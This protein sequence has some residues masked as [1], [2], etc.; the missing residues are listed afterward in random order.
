MAPNLIVNPTIVQQGYN[1]VTQAISNWVLTTDGRYMCCWLDVTTCELITGY[2]VD[3]D[4][5]SVNYAIESVVVTPSIVVTYATGSP[6]SLCRRSDGKVLLFVV[7][8][9][10]DSWVKCYIS[11]SGNG[12]DW[13]FYSLVYDSGIASNVSDKMAGYVA[14]PII[15]P[16]GRLVLLFIAGT[17]VYGSNIPTCMCAI[18][19]NNG[20]SWIIT[21][22]VVRSGVCGAGQICLLPDGSMFFSWSFSVGT[23]YLL[24]SLDSGATWTEVASWTT[25]FANSGLHGWFMSYYYDPITTTAYA[26]SDY[27]GF[28]AYLENPTGSNFSDIT[29]WTILLKDLLSSGIHSGCRI[30]MLSGYLLFHSTIDGTSYL[31]SSIPSAPLVRGGVAYVISD[32]EPRRIRK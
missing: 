10:L 21:N 16:S 15:L 28:I 18:S 19:D 22:Y 31:Y 6:T 2:S 3:L 12:D 4:F 11:A 25:T 30:Y 8:L 26:Y 9:D 5:L 13:A 1:G 7:N 32:T 17:I 23:E 24:K 14:I 27:G 29:A 20:V